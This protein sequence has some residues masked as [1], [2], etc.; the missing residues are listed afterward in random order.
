MSFKKKIYTWLLPCFALLF[1]SMN[2]YAKSPNDQSIY[3]KIVNYTGFNTPVPAHDIYYTSSWPTEYTFGLT[4]DTIAPNGANDIGLWRTG[5]AGPGIASDFVITD[6][7]A[8]N[9]V[10]FKFQMYY[11]TIDGRAV[12]FI[13][14]SDENYIIIPSVQNRDEKYAASVQIQVYDKPWEPE[15]LD[16]LIYKK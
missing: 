11:D 10:I 16:A 8:D 14:K 15:K 3:I 1:I 4:K 5:E 13:R 7:A 9:R 2:T 12:L 6:P